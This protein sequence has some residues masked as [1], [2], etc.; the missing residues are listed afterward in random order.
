[1]A[2]IRKRQWVNKKGQSK[3]CYEITYYIDG[4]QYRKSGYATKL[5]AQKDLPNV[6]K[7]IN[8]SIT[9]K[10]LAD[11]YLKEKALRCK[12]SSII[13]YKRYLNCNLKQLHNKKARELRKRDIERVIFSLKASG[14]VNKTINCILMFMSA[15]FNYGIKNKL[16]YDNPVKEIE[17]LP[18]VKN[19]IQF[20]NEDEM[21]IFI[22]YIKVFPITKHAALLTA[23]K[24]G[25]RIGELLALEWSDI[26]FCNKKISINKQVMNNVVTSPKTYTSSR[27]IDMPQPVYDILT[28]LKNETKVLSKVVFS[29]T[30]HKYMKRNAF[31]KNWFKQ[32]MKY[33]GH[34]EFTFH[35][36]RHTYTTYLMS[37]G[38]PIKYIQETLGHSS[39][40][41]LL[42]V[43][44]HVLPSARI[45]AME[46]LNYNECEQNVSIENYGH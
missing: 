34:D 21:N 39:A 22:E 13:R 7:T 12:E 16:L 6:T 46:L 41:T 1:M 24:T 38:V 14:M 2:G 10:E 25:M 19:K 31:I 30:T 4:K 29:G 5:E 32:V 45:M 20:L 3:T 35:S 11:D 28:K 17:K 43:Y 33:L 37:K 42:K 8:S 15:V 26:D 18:L 44:S 27:I 40:E 9:F 23:I 36:L